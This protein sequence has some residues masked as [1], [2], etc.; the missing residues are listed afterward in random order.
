[1]LREPFCE[2]LP[3]QLFPGQ[4][5][6]GVGGQVQDDFIQHRGGQHRQP[7]SAH[8]LRESR[9]GHVRIREAAGADHVHADAL[10]L[11]LLGHNGR[12]GLRPRLGGAVGQLAGPGHGGVAGGDIDHPAAPL[13][14]GHEAA[15]RKEEAQEVRFQHRPDGLRRDVPKGVVRGQVL[16]AGGVIADARVTDQHVQAVKPFPEPGR[17]LFHGGSVPHVHGHGTGVP[18]LRQGFFRFFQPFAGPGRDDDPG[19][20]KQQRLRHL[21]A[22]A[23]GTACNEGGIPFQIDLHPIAPLTGGYTC[24]RAFPPRRTAPG[25]DTPSRSAHKSRCGP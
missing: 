23:A 17:R 6:S 18:R 16:H 22:Q 7:G 12:H 19:P 2:V 4:V 21:E 5:R 11:Q 10:L 3:H 14:E 8:A 1:M 15:G 13:H 20:G 9:R 24:G 25:T